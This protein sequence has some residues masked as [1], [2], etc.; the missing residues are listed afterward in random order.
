[1]INIL[2]AALAR[3]TL[4]EYQAQAAIAAL[5]ADAQ[6]AQETD[7]VQIVQWYD[8]LVA[9][10]GSPVHQL[11]RAVAVGQADD[12]HA[13]LA[14]MAELDA[15]LPLHTAASAYLHEAAGEKQIAGR[16]YREA[17]DLATSTPERDHLL[18]QV[19]RLRTG[20]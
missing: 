2:Q 14:P 8:E 10:T 9:P 17:A 7:W 12:P 18:R 5:H 16:L 4:G 15:S 11:N 13:G 3:D 1:A 20:G 19:A 6:R